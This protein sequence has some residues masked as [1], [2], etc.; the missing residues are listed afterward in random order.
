MASTKGMGT[1][2][3]NDFLIGE[4]HSV[5]DVADVSG[6]LCAIGKTTI[7]GTGRNIFVGT[8]WSPWD[9]RAAHF[10]QCAD[11]GEGPE[12]RVGD[13][14]ELGLDGFEMVAGNDETGISTM[15][16]FGGETLQRQVRIKWEDG[17]VGIYHGSTV[18]PSGT[19]FLVVG[20]AGVPSETKDNRTKAAVIVLLST[21]FKRVGNSVVHGLVIAYNANVLSTLLPSGNGESR[22][23]SD[24]RLLLDVVVAAGSSKSDDADDGER[25]GAAFGGRRRRCMR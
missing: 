14:G 19:S 2:K 11:T 5:K 9:G 4:T 23:G 22:G 21:L 15:I 24:G 10:L 12:I 17:R 20:A 18:A 13:P 25:P 16:T 3:S 6:S 8:A 7:R 1:A